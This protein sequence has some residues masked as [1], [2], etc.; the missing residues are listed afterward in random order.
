MKKTLA[1]FLLLSVFLAP[2]FAFAQIASVPA[3]GAEYSPQYIALLQQLLSLLEKELAAMQSSSTGAATVSNT[4]TTGATIVP[5]SQLSIT[6][7]SLQPT[8]LQSVNLVSPS[9]WTPVNP[10]GCNAVSFGTTPALGN[11]LIGR[12]LDNTDPSNNCSGTNWSLT[13]ATI[14]WATNTITQGPKLLD[15]SAGPVKL[16]DG[17][18][19]LSA[20][21][22]TATVW[23]NEVWVAFECYGYG[24]FK[25]PAA[26]S[27]VGPL[28]KDL[29]LNLSRTVV[30]IGGTSYNA[31]DTYGYSASTPKLLTFDG[32]LYLYWS[33]VKYP[34]STPN[35]WTNITTRGIQLAEEP[36]ATKRVWALTS[37]G[38]ANQAIAA[39]DPSSV[40]VFGLNP[41]DPES[42]TSADLAQVI[43]DGSEIYFTGGRGGS[44]CLSP[45][46]TSAGC[47][48]LTIG[49]ASAPLGQDIFNQSVIPSSYLPPN[50][51]EYY[52]FVR[53]TTD[54]R[55][56]LL[57]G[58]FL[59]PTNDPTLNTGMKFLVWPTELLQYALLPAGYASTPAPYVAPT[60][61][62]TTTST[63]ATTKS[64]TSNTPVTTT[65]SSNTTVTTNS[66]TTQT[67]A[68]THPPSTT[69][70]STCGSVAI[71]ATLTP[72][73]IVSSC[74]G[75]YIFDYQTDGNVVLY[76]GSIY[77]PNAL[78]ASNTAGKTSAKLIMQTDGNL[79]LYDATNNPVWGT[80]EDGGI[81]GTPVSGL[82]IQNDGNL[83]IYGPNNSTG[84]QSILWSSNTAAAELGGT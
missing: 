52:R 76:K 71:G 74:N 32:N 4:A 79:V 24:N 81:T 17:N 34:L 10:Y 26:S 25:Y 16:G 65:A 43:T 70:S 14:N 50:P 5:A 75:T 77:G 36:T 78:W 80:I 61:P 51:E 56:V 28:N 35:A 37:Y 53:R 29:S 2:S 59:N 9:S 1:S 83:V 44:G 57:G 54:G 55:T 68:T 82:S 58:N 31:N 60:T 12:I 84:A 67:Q 40:E 27:C 63:A 6:Q 33:L 20:V 11:L 30:V 13:W 64:S 22:A 46:G 48:R 66:S 7:S 23:N 45:G 21:D 47:Y 18:S 15:T 39:N 42:N 8:W 62:V 69:T 38:L 72:G 41:N 19:I 3:S 73:T 49:S